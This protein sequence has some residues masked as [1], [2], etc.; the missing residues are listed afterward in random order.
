[1]K[2]QKYKQHYFFLYEGTSTYNLLKLFGATWLQWCAKY[3]FKLIIF[4]SSLSIGGENVLL[5]SRGHAT[6]AM[7]F[8]VINANIFDKSCFD[9]M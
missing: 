8:L 2:A 1:M 6:I 7:R 9:G 5:L 4:F 3:F